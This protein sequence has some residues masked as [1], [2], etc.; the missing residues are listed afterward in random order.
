MNFLLFLLF[1]IKVV[2]SVVKIPND[3]T[4]NL[5]CTPFYTNLSNCKSTTT[6]L[7][8]NNC[9][10]P[11]FLSDSDCGICLMEQKVTEST[12]LFNQLKA[13][14]NGQQYERVNLI[15]KNVFAS[16]VRITNPTSTT[17]V[18]TPTTDTNHNNKNKGTTELKSY[19]L[20]NTFSDSI[21]IFF[22][23]FLLFKL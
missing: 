10:C 18:F 22:T 6:I 17:N 15:I 14:C 23:S 9:I 12:K 5:R 16:N 7:D 13:A 4:C 2:L 21:L 11:V 3:F 20:K 8:V 1:V 19:S